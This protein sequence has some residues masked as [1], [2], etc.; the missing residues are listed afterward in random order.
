L[1]NYLL[2]IMTISIFNRFGALNSGPVFEAFRNGCRKHNIR[3]TEHNSAADVAVIWSQLWTGRMAPNRAVWQ[4]FTATGRPVIVLEVGQLMRGVTWKMGINGVNSRAWWGDEITP[5]RADKL[6]VRLQPWH[7][8]DH[9][10]ISMQ[11][12]DSEQWAGL[13]PA[14]QWLKQT[15]DHIRA[16]TDREIIVRPH[17]RQ[18]LNPMPGVQIQQPQA[19]RGTYDEFDFRSNLN[20]AWAV[21]NENS[22]P[23]SQAV[24]DGVPAFVGAYSM[25]APVAN[26]DFSHIEKPL[27]PERAEWLE[28]LCH[29]E[30]TLGEITSGLPLGRLLGRLKSN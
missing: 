27:M 19:L 23:G 24:I 8:G 20:R 1:N 13:P 9:I 16:H 11:R 21:V 18:K 22:G 7:Q 2:H 15:I 3:V 30:W 29:T 4:E 12:T 6:S 10:L 14:D 17:P 26:Q 28:R 25:A 5:G